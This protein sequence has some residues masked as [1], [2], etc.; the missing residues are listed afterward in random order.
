MLLHA[1]AIQRAV[2]DVL[3]GDQV[4]TEV[5]LLFVSPDHGILLQEYQAL[6]GTGGWCG[7]RDP[8]IISLCWCYQFMALHSLHITNCH[9]CLLKHRANPGG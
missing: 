5:A 6:D 1:Q 3:G 8:M 7:S 2:D 9:L 4:M